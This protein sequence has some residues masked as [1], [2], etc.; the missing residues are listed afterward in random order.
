[1]T[2][3][4]VKMWTYQLDAIVCLG[5]Q[6]NTHHTHHTKTMP[7]SRVTPSSLIDQNEIAS[8]LQ[9]ESNGLRLSAIEITAKSR[10]Q[11]LILALAE[12]PDDISLPILIEV[13]R[14]HP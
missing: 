11:S 3:E 7:L 13:A 8:E 4:S 5:I 9:S 1:M 10:H 14:N 12:M 2:P 6:K